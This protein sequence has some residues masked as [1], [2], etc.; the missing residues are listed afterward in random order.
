MYKRGLTYG[1]FDLLHTGHIKLL[2]RARGLCDY[3]IVGVQEDEGVMLQ[4]PRPILSTEERVKLVR[5][6]GIADEVVTYY[7]SVGPGDFSVHKIDAYIHG[8][9]WKEQTDR[10][11]V[12]KYFE[13]NNIDL[14][15]LPR[16]SGISTSDI[17]YRIKKY[18]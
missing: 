12:L 10:S 3:L 14:V 5:S 13:D 7:N 17:I 4:K 8:E 11:K 2:Q 9:D 1:V 18:R 15:L 6:L 16:T